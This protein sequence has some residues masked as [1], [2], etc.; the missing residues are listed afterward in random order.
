MDDPFDEIADRIGT[1]PRRFRWWTRLTYLH[2]PKPSWLTADD[3]LHTFFHNL[4]QVWRHGLLT[5][6]QV[7]QANHTASEPGRHNFPGDI[8]YSLDWIPQ[9]PAFRLAEIA[10]ACFDLKV[11]SPADPE[12]ALVATHLSRERN[13]TYGT[14]VP[15]AIAP[16]LRCRISCTYFVRKHLPDGKLCFPL[17]PILVNSTSP[18][19]IATVPGKYWPTRFA[20]WWVSKA[21]TQQ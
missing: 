5:W 19:V 20:D 4:P 9:V 17:V 7:V 11:Q 2:V 14:P 16:D 18:C 3:E 6:G 1:A 15:S 21:R 10:Y 13:R 12:L 8:L